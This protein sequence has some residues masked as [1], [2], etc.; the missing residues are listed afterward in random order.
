MNKKEASQ[1]K[2][3]TIKMKVNSYQTISILKLLNKKAK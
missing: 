1:M 2:T 3:A